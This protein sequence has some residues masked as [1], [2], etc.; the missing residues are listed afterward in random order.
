MRHALLIPRAPQ[1]LTSIELVLRI[2]QTTY[3]VMQMAA[4]LDRAKNLQDW[5][6]VSA[7]QHAVRV[8]EEHNAIE[9]DLVCAAEGLASETA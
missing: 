1:K 6:L 2:P 9:Q 5:I 8:R 4:R 7:W 3:R